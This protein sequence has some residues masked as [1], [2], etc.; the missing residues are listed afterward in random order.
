MFQHLLLNFLMYWLYNLLS[1]LNS[2]TFLFEMIYISLK[3][4][5]IY[6]Y[7]ILHI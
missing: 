3:N 5:S 4:T 2:K 6:I 7:L 1:T